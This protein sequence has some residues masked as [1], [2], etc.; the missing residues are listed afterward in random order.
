MLPVS[1]WTRPPVSLR[2]PG[3]EVMFNSGAARALVTEQMM[4]LA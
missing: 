2:W 4:G 3:G 1:A